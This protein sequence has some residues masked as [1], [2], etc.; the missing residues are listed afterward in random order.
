MKT[1]LF[2]SLIIV[3]LTFNNSYAQANVKFN[4]TFSS[5]NTSHIKLDIEKKDLTLKTTKGSRIVVEM[6]IKIS[7]PN[8]NLLEF[9]TESGRYRLEK[10]FDAETKT[11][12]LKN[13]K[14]KNIITIKGKEVTE[15]ISYV[16]YLPETMQLVTDTTSSNL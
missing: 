12:T 6:L 7:S 14:H 2:F 16:I 13:K 1:K 8:T 10:L 4:Q 5:I 9:I 11:L 15:Q 3:V